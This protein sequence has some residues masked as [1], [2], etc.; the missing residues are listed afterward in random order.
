MTDERYSKLLNLHERLKEVKSMKKSAAKD[1]RDQ[2]KEIE[3]EIE[4]LVEDIR[5]QPEK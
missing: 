3:E 2:I 4:G 5:E 1:Y